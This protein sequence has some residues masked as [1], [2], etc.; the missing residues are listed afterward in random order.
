ML[1]YA[2]LKYNILEKYFYALVKSLKAFQFYIL[3]P[4]IIAYVPIVVVKDI[5]MQDDNESK[6]GKWISKIQQYDM[7]IKPTKLIK[8]R[9]LS[10]ILSEANCQAFVINLLENMEGESKGEEE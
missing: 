9:G 7:D 6:R 1:Q 5:L 10:K 3:Q 2:E 4:N 8:G